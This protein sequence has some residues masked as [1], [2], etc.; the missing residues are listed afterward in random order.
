[1]NVFLSTVLIFVASLGRTRA[2]DADAFDTAFDRRPG[3]ICEAN[4]ANALGT[5][6]ANVDA[7]TVQ[8]L[9]NEKCTGFQFEQV[10]TKGKK[11]KNGKKRKVKMQNHCTIFTTTISGFDPVGNSN[12]ACFLKSGVYPPP[13]NHYVL[14][15]FTNGDQRGPCP[16]INTLANHGFI[17][18]NG[19]GVLMVDLLKALSEV[20]DIHEQTLINGPGVV[21]A[22][23]FGLTTLIPGR[24][25]GSTAIEDHFLDLSN[26]FLRPG[27]LEHD[28]SL[29][30]TDSFFC[31]NEKSLL[32]NDAR[33]DGLLAM[34]GDKSFLDRDDI[35]AYRRNRILDTKIFNNDTMSSTFPVILGMTIESML[36]MIVGQDERLDRIDKKTLEQ[37]LRNETIPD[38]YAPTAGLKYTVQGD[39]ASEIML[40]FGA[41]IAA[42]VGEVV[43]EAKVEANSRCPT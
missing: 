22:L 31:D 21:G 11:R 18:R 7:C 23:A 16:A 34:A 25:A 2:A 43:V 24:V 14:P 36:L 1:M 37:W 33:I 20:Y 28:A 38:G 3:T 8:C 13:G 12:T 9:L 5:K 30:R 40:E 15:D 27:K 19:K 26:L 32:A 10:K 39:R 35:A 6:I 42:A 29:A 17:N 4:S 41:T